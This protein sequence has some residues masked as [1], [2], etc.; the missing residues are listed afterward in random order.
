[1]LALCHVMDLAMRGEGYRGLVL[2]LSPTIST[3][4]SVMGHIVEAIKFDPELAGQFKSNVA[5]RQITHVRSGIV[6]EIAPP[7]MD[8]VVG[9]RPICLLWRMKFT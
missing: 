8:A 3:A 5:R 9:R 6:L 4:D 7:R 1:M 2:L